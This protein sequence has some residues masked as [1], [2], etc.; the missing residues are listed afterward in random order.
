[1]KNLLIIFRGWSSTPNLYKRIEKTGTASEMDNLALAAVISTHLLHRQFIENVND[2]F[3]PPGLKNL[4]I[5]EDY[6]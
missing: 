1:M 2:D 3:R 4:K 6:K 5:I